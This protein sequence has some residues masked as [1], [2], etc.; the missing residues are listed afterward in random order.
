M[1]KV[2]CS[3]LMWG[4]TRLELVL[5][6]LAEIGYQGVEA[7]EATFQEFAKQPARLRGL[8]D[9]RGLAVS[10]A[11]FTAW[12]FER[13]ERANEVERLRRLADFLGET[14]HQAIIVFRTVPHPARRDMVAG[15][16][17]LLPLTHDRLGHLADAL[18]QY[19]EICRDFDLIG[20][21]QNRVGSFWETPDEYEQVA[22]RTDAQLVRLAPD[23]GHWAYAGGDP[24]VLVQTHGGRF[25][26]P[27][28]K[29]L[30]QTVF[31]RVRDERQGFRSFLSAGGFKELGQGSLAIEG[32]L[33]P[34]REA[35]YDGWVCL[36]L[37]H[38]ARTPKDSA[39]I[40]REYLRDH[41][42]W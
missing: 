5:D 35:D 26:Y 39:L 38:T 23:L 3:P 41:L 9:E 17:P 20:A 18:N 25:V 31:D 16:P 22:E 40:S 6:D 15:E 7:H 13:A 37:E 42:H 12:Y 14:G 33:Q 27:R 34:L 10:A 32:V 2:A 21:I 4:E 1:V 8:V 30:D 36:E 11:P 24:L 28:V 19:G 29:D